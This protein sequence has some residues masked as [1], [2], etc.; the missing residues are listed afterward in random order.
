M[1]NRRIL[2]RYLKAKVENLKMKSSMPRRTEKILEVSEKTIR[3]HNLHPF[4][5]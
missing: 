3:T 2:E 1:K 4:L 5:E